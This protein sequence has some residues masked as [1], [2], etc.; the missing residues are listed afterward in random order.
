MRENDAIQSI[1]R[2]T[3]SFSCFPRNPDLVHIWED[4][5]S[6]V[7]SSSLRKITTTTRTTTPKMMF[8]REVMRMARI[9][10]GTSGRRGLLRSVPLMNEQPEVNVT[11]ITPKG[12][13]VPCKAT[14]G[15]TILELAH[16]N[17]VDLEGYVIRHHRD[18]IVSDT[19]I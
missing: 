14:E 11:F 8:M 5:A 9:P 7:V 17:D 16:A 12:E 19:N 6:C 18:P 1:R 15:T 4:K 10:A 2:M 13:R 3:L